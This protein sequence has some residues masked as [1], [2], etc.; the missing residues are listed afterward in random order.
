MNCCTVA[1]VMSNE[2]SSVPS[3]TM[4]SGAPDASKRQGSDGVNGLTN[5]I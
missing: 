2:V 5:A 1:F 4:Q 3:S